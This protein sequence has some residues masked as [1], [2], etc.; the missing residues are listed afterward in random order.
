MLKDFML[1]IPLSRQV[2]FE[3]KD[4]ASKASGFASKFFKANDDLPILILVDLRTS[5]SWGQHIFF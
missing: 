3:L 4:D 1:R 5:Y 2:I